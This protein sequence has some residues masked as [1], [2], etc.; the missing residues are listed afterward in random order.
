MGG[1]KILLAGGRI[2]RI[3]NS[4]F[5]VYAED[6]KRYQVGWINRKWRCDCRRPRVCKHVNA[7]SLLLQL[8]HI[9]TM[10]LNPEQFTCPS[11]GALWRELDKSG[12]QRNK[13][14]MVQRYKCSA[15]GLRFN[16][17]RN[18]EKLRSNPT[19]ILLSVD[20]FFEGLS[21][22]QITNH[23][24]SFYASD[25][26]HVT[27]YR[28]I[29][30]YTEALR[31]VEEKMAKSLLIG[32]HWHSDET[33]AKVQSEL[34]YV[35]NIL[36]HRTRY[37][38]ASV[39]TSGRNAETF[40]KILT[41]SIRKMGRHP[42]KMT[43]DGLPSYQI[44]LRRRPSIRHVRG[45]KL[46]DKANNNILERANKTMKKRLRSMEKFSDPNSAKT[47]VDGFRLY[48]NLVRPHMSLA[49]QTPAERAGLKFKSKNK[50]L[51][52]VNLQARI[53]GKQV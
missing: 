29:K 13:S 5:V 10:N 53:Q 18:F 4:E 31:R 42:K 41:D 24:N 39:V 6:D 46:K 32:S 37:L 1:M 26:S 20:L 28:W 23:L 45:R 35:W 11:C 43:T 7:V 27:I 33:C 38:L 3:S 19:L 48:Y 15:C 47:V 2:T 30:K 12:I 36:D 49:N 44:A 34:K 40:D 50:L 21:T 14:G 25:V 16:D 52:V 22:R 9:I 8:P 17:R 51:E